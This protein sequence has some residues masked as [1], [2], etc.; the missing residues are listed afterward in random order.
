VAGILQ[1]IVCFLGPI[2]LRINKK[3]MPESV[4]TNLV[5]VAQRRF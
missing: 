3:L 1:T 2:A 4:W 5:Y